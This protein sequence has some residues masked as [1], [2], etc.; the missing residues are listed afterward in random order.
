M[1]QPGGQGVR[2]LR[3]L[4]VFGSKTSFTGFFYGFYMGVSGFIGFSEGVM[5]YVAFGYAA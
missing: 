3:N 4:E 2:V 5:S 1:L